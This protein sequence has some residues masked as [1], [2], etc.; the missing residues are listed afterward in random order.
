MEKQF[1][2]LARRVEM[3]EKM[4]ENDLEKINENNIKL[5][6]I[7][8]ELKNITYRIGEL[9]SNLEKSISRSEKQKK[10]DHDVIYERISNLEGLYKALDEELDQRTINQKAETLDKI[11]WRITVLLLSALVSGII[12]SFVILQ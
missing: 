7:I 9:T 1:E 12:S 6:E 3:L 4:R 5:T 10:V 8:F 11:K 2:T